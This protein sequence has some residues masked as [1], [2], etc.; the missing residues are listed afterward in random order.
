MKPAVDDLPPGLIVQFP[1]TRTRNGSRLQVP[2]DLYWRPSG[3]V[4][5]GLLTVQPQGEPPTQYLLCELRADAGRLW[6]LQRRDTGERHHVRREALRFSC[7]CRG[8]VRQGYCRHCD[9]MGWL[10]R[11]GY[12]EIRDGLYL[13]V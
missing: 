7:D 5:G 6:V 3:Q 1:V 12:F 4:V 10:D 2:F 11:E 9:A 13:S 8:F